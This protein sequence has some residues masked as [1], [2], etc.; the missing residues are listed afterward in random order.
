[1][2]HA[3]LLCLVAAVC[4]L[5]AVA[6]ADVPTLINYQGILTDAG[7][8]PITAPV[9][10]SFSIFQDPAGGTA[11]WTES[12]S[13]TPDADGRFTVLLGAVNPIPTTMFDWHE[14]YLEVQVSGDTPF[15]RIRFISVAYAYHAKRSDSAS[16]SFSAAPGSVNSDAIIDGTILF[17]DMAPNGAASGQ[18]M[19]WNGSAWVAG[20]DETGGG[21]GGGWVDDGTVVRLET[22]SDNVGIGTSSPSSKLD[23]VGDLEVSGKATIG[24][25]HTNTGTDAFVAGANNTAS[26]LAASVSGGQFNTAGGSNATVGGGSNNVASAD[27]TTVGGGFLNVASGTNSVVGGGVSDTASGEGATISGGYDNSALN[28][29]STIGGGAGNVVAADYATVGGGGQDTASGYGAVIAGGQVNVA[30]GSYAAVGGGTSNTASARY[31]TVG[32]GYLDT[33][34]SDASTVSGGWHNVATGPSSFVGSGQENIASGYSA[35]VGGGNYNKA[36]GHASVVAGGGDYEADSN[37]ALGR[38]SVVGGGKR[39]YAVGNYGVIA[40]G[41]SNRAMG[42]ESVIAGGALNCS[43]FSYDFVGGG[44]R[45]VARGGTAV[46]CGGGTLNFI[47]SNVA[48][49]EASFIGAGVGNRTVSSE[50]VVGGGMW[51][52]AGYLS[53]VAGGDS[54]WVG[55]NSIWYR[56][57]AVGGGHS[58]IAMARYATVGGGSYNRAWADG[59]VVAGGGSGNPADSNAAYGLCSA[60]GGGVA[61]LAY[62]LYATVPGGRSNTA[63]ASYSF[64]AGRRSKA[65]HNGSFVWADQTDADFASTGV[66]QFLIRAAGGVGIGTNSP[67]MPLTVAGTIYSTSG[68]FKFPDGTTQTTSATSGT[69]S[70]WADDGTVVRLQTV[71][72]NV[73]IGTAS[74]SEKLDVN[75]LLHMRDNIK[76]NGNWLSNDGGDEGVWID[77]DGDVGIRTSSPTVPLTV[78]GGTDVS[79]ASGGYVTI[80]SMDATNI[81]VDDNEIMARNNGAAE[82]LHLNNSSGNVIICQ[83]GGNV[84]I[85]TGS[86]AGALDVSSTTGAFIVPR[87]TTAQ[88]DALTAVNGMII[89]NTTTN[90]FNFR[91]NGA[92]VTK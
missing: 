43:W 60:I 76:L 82:T 25:G 89:Y 38:N 32:G 16:L 91:E 45:N 10:V 79:L 24:P 26:A 33:A 18:V 13:V 15:P 5:P 83:S 72:D 70:G 21:G 75:G 27:R 81:T 46:V 63:G 4:L 34:S 50:A 1:M 31:A 68:G 49:G 61:N 44:I 6:F 39:N 29:Y 56:N 71:T 35:V 74:P 55:E 7:G 8:A 41:R 69:S 64:A 66:D 48:V 17:S 92:W 36:R 9:N 19:K 57:C 3:F 67:S 58:N 73:G 23:V 62:G 20:T 65:N 78:K 51:N 88:R 40:G 85:G 30:S 86:P 80:G 84:G 52:S 22:T 59:S 37:L 87:M 90:Q 47:D 11:G 77:T 28:L 12:Q 42:D 14:R 2:R 53:V 54:N